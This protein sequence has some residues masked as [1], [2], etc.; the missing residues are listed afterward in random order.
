[1]KHV[2][3]FES[4]RWAGGWVSGVVQG[5]AWVTYISLPFLILSLTQVI[6]LRDALNIFSIKLINDVLSIAFFYA[7]LHIITPLT[8]RR[9]QLWP[10]LLALGGLGLLLL[11]VDTLYYEWYLRDVMVQIARRFPTIPMIEHSPVWGIPLPIVLIS[12]LSLLLLT[13]VS[14]GFAIYRDRS[15]HVAASQQMIIQKQQAEL[16]S[17]KLQISPHFLFN[18]LNNLRWLVRTKSVD[19]EE[20]VLRLSEMMRYMIYQVDKGPVPLTREIGYL[21]HYVDLQTMRLSPNNRVSLDFDA[22]NPWA[23]VEP[24][25]FVHFVENAFKHGLHPDDEAWIAIRLTLRDGVLR[26]QTQNRV[27]SQPADPDSG[28][29]IQNTRRRLQL[30]YPNQHELRI[31]RQEDV[32]GVDLTIRLAP[33]PQPQPQP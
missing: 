16:T 26:F 3:F 9:R 5:L 23:L 18:T 8:L 4:F 6:G 2:A 11:L 10:F 31:S 29:G 20:A 33:T 22:D 1:M 15:Q 17:L 28:I 30:H 27:F 7:N 21:K 14:S 24:L 12:I 13:S 19:A 25:L 32:F